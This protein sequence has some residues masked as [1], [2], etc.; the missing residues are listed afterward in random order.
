LSRHSKTRA[1]R[2][3]GKWQVDPQALRE[4][5]LRLTPLLLG[6]LAFVVYLL[7]MA[8]VLTWAH[9]GRDGGDLI[10]AARFLGVPHPTGY[11]TYTM[12][13][14]LF[15][16]LPLG[17]VA[18]RVHLLSGLA[19][20]VTVALVYVIGRRLAAEEMR[21]PAALGAAVGALLLAFSPLFWGQSLIAEVYTLHLFFITL[22]LWL[23]LRWRD[24]E[25][26]LPL[27]ALAFGL[28]MGN[29]ITL[30][31]LGPAILLLLWSGRERLSL[32]VVLGSA[33]AL[34]AG[35][36][37]YLYLPWRAA[38]NPVINWGNPETWEGFSW[39]ISGQGYRRFFFA[40]PADEL[41]SRLEDWWN[42]SGDQF[43][44]LA[45]PL[46]AWGLWGLA[47]RHRW[48]A[49]GTF[50]HVAINLVYSIGYDVSDAFVHL[51]PVYLY[52]ALWMGQGAVYL[53]MA[54]IRLGRPG[55]RPQEVLTLVTVGLLVLPVVSLAEEWAGMDL[56]HD[57]DA[58]NYA[59]EALELV[60]PD[61]LILVGSDV[62]TFALWYQRYVEGLRP[63]V[64][65]VN[66]AMLSFDWYQ[67]T[68]ASYHPDVVLPSPDDA[69]TT[70]LAHV[71]RNL[72][73]RAVYIA[74]DE[75]DL[76]GLQLTPVG[77]LWRVTTP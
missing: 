69:K 9:A 6:G 54:I 60:E 62:Y 38:T 14:W 7:T 71:L 57:R 1:K 12:L 27:A 72:N 65:T 70:K 74:E 73:G 22:I 76:P 11:P 2:H 41:T 48:L 8:P 43:P 35:L 67:R 61:A 45:W 77:S 33:L 39:V 32:R 44:I 23:T 13:A 55:Q 31:F 49:L 75:D 36:L 47:R 24:G 51:L 3:I 68:V 17:S 18:W 20:A 63:D 21:E 59:Q 58:Y 50:L 46:A 4:R 40:L 26:P 19:A 37:V 25:S 29:H 28:G 34:A 66:Y 52:L 15:T 10:T 5:S 64:A 42:L 53:L 30:T 56:T 16:R